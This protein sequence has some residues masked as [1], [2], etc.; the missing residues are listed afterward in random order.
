MHDHHNL[1]SIHSAAPTRGARF[2]ASPAYV[3]YA[4][5]TLIS[6]ITT[7]CIWYNYDRTFD[8]SSLQIIYQ[9]ATAPQDISQWLLQPFARHGDSAVVIFLTSIHAA[10][11]LLFMRIGENIGI[12]RRTLLL[13]FILFNFSPEYND[14]RLQPEP[15]LGFILLWLIAVWWFLRWYEKSLTIGFMGWSACTWLS[16]LFAYSAILWAIG[17]PLCFLL[18]PRQH[19]GAHRW[20]I[21]ERERN[22]LLYYLAVALL[23]AIIPWWRENLTRLYHLAYEQ[24]HLATTE[25]AIFLSPDSGGLELDIAS[26][27]L[28]ILVLVALN[29]LKIAGILIV[30]FLWLSIRAHTKSVLNGRVRL[31]FTYSLIFSMLISAAT[32]LYQNRLQ[33]DLY[34]IPILCLFLWLASNGAYYAVQRLE[35]HSIAPE[36]LL[37]LTWVLIAYA[38]VSIIQ[39]G[40]SPVYQRQAGQFAA[41]LHPAKIYS[42]SPTALYY[43][44]LSPANHNITDEET[45]LIDTPAMLDDLI[46]LTLNRHRQPPAELAHYQTLATYRNRHGDT[47]YVLKPKP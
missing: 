40:P 44:G 36:R 38:L 18:W 14:V 25:M 1:S 21:G 22:I 10:I 20:R 5:L 4:T 17:F 45:L 29:A 42:N 33:S 16:A 47:A 7:L 35:N 43:A 39:F 41:S 19:R 27:F 32:V 3:W 13:L 37:I 46:I 31:F 8:R 28:I 15:Y 30:F 23:I 2:F 9:A 24:I 12:G 6:G 11:A 34:Y 26:A